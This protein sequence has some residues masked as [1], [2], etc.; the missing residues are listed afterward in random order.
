M[1]T[2][3]SVALGAVAVVVLLA[4]CLSGAGVGQPQSPTDEPVDDTQTPTDE[5][6][7]SGE[8]CVNGVSFYGLNGPGNSLWAPDTVVIGYTAPANASLLFVVFE[9]G[10]AIGTTHVT[11]TNLDHA[12][13]A[14]GD[15]IPLD[16]PAS[17]SHTIRVGAYADTNGNGEFD[18]G[19]DRPCRTD[20]EPVEAGP[21]RINFSAFDAGHASPTPAKTPPQENS[22]PP[23]E[24]LSVRALP[25]QPSTLTNE[26][27]VAF[28]SAYEEAI[29]WNDHLDNQTLSMGVSVSKATVV[30]RTASGY[31][32]HV[33]G[34][35]GFEKCLDGGHVAGDGFINANYFVNGTTAVRLQH[36]DSVTA[37]PRE[38]GTV[39]ERW[40]RSTGE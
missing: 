14:D 35:L 26:T 24:N 15:G 32:V 29:V 22:C 27:A 10:N 7:Q 3:S 40:E 38:R 30:D 23:A 17:G 9:D 31:V 8:N 37:D 20:G 4:G 25:Q 12:V 11:T 5:P 16:R 13:V 2:K 18:A 21:R 39:V 33:E 19:T 6:L 36:P 28:A 1:V 34:G